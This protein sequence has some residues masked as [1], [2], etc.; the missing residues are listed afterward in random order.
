VEEAGVVALVGGAEESISVLVGL[1]AVGHAAEFP[2]VFG[3]AILADAKED[4]AVDGFL[5]G[6]VKITDGEYRIP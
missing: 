4:E 6:E 1:R 3:T 2:V 5:N